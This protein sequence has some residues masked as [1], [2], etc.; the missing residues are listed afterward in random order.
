M[1]DVAGI[2]LF[3]MPVMFFCNSDALD[4][5]YVTKNAFYTKHPIERSASKPLLYNNIVNMDTDDPLY[6]K[7]RKAL[8]SAFFKS[9][10]E[11]ITNTVKSTAMSA[12]AMLQAKGDVNEVDINSYT[13]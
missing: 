3:G 2:M 9:K 12:F 4:E 10:M 1:P 11:V 6:K 7:K 13:S 8:S 5:L